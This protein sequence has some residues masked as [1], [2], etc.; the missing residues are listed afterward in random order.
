MKADK[1]DRALTDQVCKLICGSIPKRPVLPAARKGRSLIGFSLPSDCSASFG[2]KRGADP[3]ADV[4][5]TWLH[6]TVLRWSESQ[7]HV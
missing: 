3:L 2:C 1:A 7:V 5:Y 6:K 4:G